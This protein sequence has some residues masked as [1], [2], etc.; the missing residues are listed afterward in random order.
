[1]RFHVSLGYLAVLA[2]VAAVSGCST[3]GATVGDLSDAELSSKCDGRALLFRVKQEFESEATQSGAPRLYGSWN[4][5]GDVSAS[6]LRTGSIVSRVQVSEHASGVFSQVDVLTQNAKG[7]RGWLSSNALEPVGASGCDAVLE[8]DASMVERIAFRNTSLPAELAEATLQCTLG[9]SEGVW[10]GAVGFVGG[11]ASM[12]VVS[13][14]LIAEVAR[15]DRDII[16]LGLGSR[17]ASERIARAGASDRE[18]A[19]AAISLV[20]HAIPAMHAYVGQRYKY[21]QLLDAPHQSQFLCKIIGRVGFEVAVNIAQNSKLEAAVNKDL[22]LKI[23]SA[24]ASELPRADI[25]GRLGTSDVVDING[26]VKS[27]RTDAW[28]SHRVTTDQAA[29]FGKDFESVYQE[30][31]KTKD[32]VKRK[33]LIAALNDTT[34]PAFKLGWVTSGN[35]SFQAHTSLFMLATG[36]AF[37]AMKEGFPS[38]A[39]SVLTGLKASGAQIVLG[40]EVPASGLVK[41]AEAIPE[42]GLAMLISVGKDSGHATIVT[43]LNGTLLHINNQ[44]WNV[45]A[46]GQDIIDLASWPQ[47]WEKAI[48]TVS[49]YAVVLTD[50][51]I[52]FKP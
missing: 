22:T 43:R 21:Y 40:A 41:A 10:D 17:E 37:C 33:N 24:V 25:P 47:Q 50:Q 34:N 12:V 27:L 19:A 3:E 39:Q 2:L 1:M 31:L 51:K 23:E 16:L 32:L 7:T 8:Q 46:N 36:G 35:C 13:S 26:A 28:V 44:N 14:K 48:G 45:L 42:G 29:K 5:I 20:G 18:R 11:M 38:D 6:R 49:S 9:L 30:L 4:N 52:P 15:R